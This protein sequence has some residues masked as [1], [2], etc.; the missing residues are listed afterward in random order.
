M[1]TRNSRLWPS[2][3]VVA[4]L[5]IVGIGVAGVAAAAPTESSAQAVKKSTVKKIA[6]N[7]ANKAITAR[8]PGLSV[9]S[10]QSAAP[11]GPAGGDLT[12]TYPNPVIGPN[13]VTTTKI[14]DAAVTTIKLADAAVTT[15]K[16]ADAAVTTGKLADNAVT[17][18]KIV[19]GSVRAGEVGPTQLVSNTGPIAANGTAGIAV[20]CPAGTQILSGGGTTSIFGVHL[21]STFQSGNGWIVAYQNTTAAAQTI[22]AAATCL[23]A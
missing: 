1:I 19:D 5:A 11:V 22:T 15:T 17:S 4:S 23:N 12:G 16:L 21:V 18:A 8:A 13:A 6:R 10:A 14:A 7:Q 3:A 2:P 20:Q 9:L